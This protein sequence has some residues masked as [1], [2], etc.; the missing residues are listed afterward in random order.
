V[1]ESLH[2]RLAAALAT[3]LAERS[4][5]LRGGARRV[6]WKLGTGDRER[7]GSGPV[8]GYLTSASR[9]P[10]GASYRPAAGEELHADAEVALHLRR[11]LEAQ[12]GVDAAREAI[13]AY[14]A[15]LEL[16]DLGGEDDAERI[17]AAN[18]FHRAF[19]LAPPLRV[20]P[21]GTTARLL[22]DGE[23]RAEGDARADYG[24][25][26]V[27]AA[28]LLEAIGERLEAGDAIITGSVVQIPVRPGEEV[29]AE[30]GRLGRVGLRVAS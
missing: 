23:V 7:I 8:V 2:P 10:E 3:Q 29:V 14:G 12:E 24:A 21:A 30:F 19:A 27:E 26:V 22:V 25:L 15:A 6:G 11:A 18:V 9:L 5:L 20:L 1:S 28:G 16:V 4:A 13:A 17:V